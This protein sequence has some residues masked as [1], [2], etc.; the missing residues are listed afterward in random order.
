MS[1][2]G[3]IHDP[4]V[5]TAHYNEGKFARQPLCCPLGED[6]VNSTNDYP[7][8]RLDTFSTLVVRKY[9]QVPYNLP[10]EVPLLGKFSGQPMGSLFAITGQMSSRFSRM[11]FY[12][13]GCCEFC[14]ILQHHQIPYTQLCL[15]YLHSAKTTIL[16]G[17]TVHSATA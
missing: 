16:S 14:R 15:S 8:L 17:G 11:I 2:G 3:A 10:S 5:G 13:H 9:V 12:L 1:F 7:Y 4:P 6:L